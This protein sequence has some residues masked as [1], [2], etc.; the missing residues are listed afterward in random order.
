MSIFGRAA[1]AAAALVLIVGTACVDEQIVYRDRDLTGDIPA[2]HQGFLGLSNEDTN[3]TV[4]GNCHVSYQGQWEETAHAQAW[5]TLQ[6]SG[7]AQAFCQNCHTVNQLGNLTEEAGGFATTSDSR[8]HNVQC[9]S[10]HGPGLAHVQN[11]GDD[12]IPLA[13]LDVGLDMTTGCGECH[14]GA[15]HPFVDEWSQSGHGTVVAYPA[16]RAECTSCHTGEGALAAWGINAD[17]AEKETVAQAD[18]HLAITCGVCHDPHDATN[19]GQLRFPIDVPNE[20]QNLCM[21]CHHKR[22]TPDLASQGRG[23]HSPEGPVLLGYG[24]WWPPNL[25]FPGEGDTATIVAT[26]GSTANPRLC[27]G[28]HVNAYTAVDELTGGTIVST[29]HLFQAIP[30]MENGRPVVGDCAPSERN[31]QTCTG[32]GCHGSQNVARSLQQVAEQRLDALATELNALIAQIPASEFDANDGRYSTGEGAKFNHDLAR[33]PG[34]AIHNPFLVEALL[35][36]SIQQV[37]TDYGVS[38]ASTVSLERELGTD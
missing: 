19:A 36:A 15:H 38:A 7:S 11:P 29:G 18:E 17:Y 8:Y 12:N 4:C 20:E 34:S 13:P 10:C 16:G 24:G 23:P 6:N 14:S 25:Q 1:A 2:G 37:E 9:E 33:Y 30:C 28:C 26:H 22:G 3:L 5:A 27:A 35:I 21:K 32:A 31:Y